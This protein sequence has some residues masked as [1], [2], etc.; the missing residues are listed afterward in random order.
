M[1]YIKCPDCGKELRVFGDS[2]IDEIANE[3]GYDLLAKVPIDTEVASYVDKGWIE[4]VKADYLSA[5]ADAIVEKCN[6]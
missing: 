5:A 3:F 1:S 2:H 6:K 4:T